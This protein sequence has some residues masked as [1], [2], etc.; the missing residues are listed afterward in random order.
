MVFWS[1]GR[2][3]PVARESRGGG[4]LSLD[5]VRR[6][7]S[8]LTLVVLTWISPARA[9]DV[10]SYR[11]VSCYNAVLDPAAQFFVR[12]MEGDGND[13]TVVARPNLASVL[14]RRW[15]ADPKDPSRLMP[16]E[17][18]DIQVN[19]QPPGILSPVFED[20]TGDGRLDLFVTSES[21]QHVS[22]PDG[23]T[24]LFITTYAPIAPLSLLGPFL[25]GCSR[26]VENSPG[27]VN[28]MAAVDVNKDGRR[29]VLLFD[30]PF[31]V[32]CESR[33]LRAYDAV[34]GR[35][36]WRFVVPTPPGDV[37]VWEPPPGGAQSPVVLMGAFACDNGFRIGEWSDRESRIT[38]LSLDGA[39]L[40]Q[41]RIGGQGTGT[42]LMLADRDGDGRQEPYV[43]VQGNRNAE[44]H[45]PSPFVY[46]IEPE[47]GAL[48]PFAVPEYVNGFRAADLDG[49]P[50][51][52][53]LLI[54]RDQVLYALRRDFTLA[55]QYRD[56]RVRGVIAVADLDGDGHP[57]I[58]C[59][60]GDI[61]RILDRRGQ[62][63]AQAGL[64][65]I[66]TLTRTACARIGGHAY[67]VVRQGDQLKFLHLRRM[68]AGVP[69]WLWVLGTSLVFTA[70]LLV[71][72]I[73]RTKAC[74][75]F[76]DEF[77]ELR[78][79][80]GA[81]PFVTIRRLSQ[82]LLSWRHI[83]EQGGVAASPLPRLIVD[84][85]QRVLPPLRR[86]ASLG[87][88]TGLP[89]RL[90]AGLDADAQLVYDHLRQLLMAEEAALPDRFAR[91][92]RVL[93]GFTERCSRVEDRFP[94]PAS[95]SEV[96]RKVIEQRHV[97]LLCNG[98]EAEVMAT[99]DDSH[100]TDF[101]ADELQFILDNCVENSVRALTGHQNPRLTISIGCEGR[102]CLVDVADNGA[103]IPLPKGQWARIFDADFTTR[104]AE[105]GE[106]GGGF[107]LHRA[108]HLLRRGGGRITVLHSRQGGGT[109]MRITLRAY[110]PR[111]RQAK[112]TRGARASQAASAAEG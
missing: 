76:E 103:G 105:A 49:R 109:T 94:M 48:T 73:V 3:F 62:E 32:G 24:G 80:H 18:Q 106:G 70:G 25:Q 8:A 93:Q 53:I 58:L 1:W 107:G 10:P 5:L 75:E 63:L 101:P 17:N 59:D 74:R 21:G 92:T 16:Y 15:G 104:R 28:V 33:S 54:G 41:T 4:K 38:G 96:A 37:I 57:E 20:V 56:D 100:R 31:A 7:I 27:Q 82:L 44:G 95:V 64:S 9:T 85:G 88:R 26:R 12:D 61:V 87:P 35:E 83:S 84:F 36:L 14:I 98:V 67:V 34:T 52:E 42:R 13:E 6:K 90:W 97:D 29:D 111:R 108:R 72:Q 110:R 40:W 19:L 60:C 71:L 45:E 99:D 51:D 2:F 89:R 79:G 46:A 66:A 39:F 55:W 43:S 50:G 68:P 65:G 47:S 23:F 30:Y 69:A 112:R 102:F 91:A 78:H 77:M 86:M 11:L 22:S 81:A